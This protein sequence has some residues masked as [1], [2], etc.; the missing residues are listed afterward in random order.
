[1]SP[2]WLSM[3]ICVGAF[4]SLVA[5]LRQTRMSLGLPVAYLFGLL[6]NHLPG[7]LAQSLSNGLLPGFLYTNVGM[8]ITAVSSVS[9]LVGVYLASRGRAPSL[10]LAPADRAGFA[11]F[12]LIGG[13]FFTYALSFLSSIP[14]IGAAVHEGGAIW[15]LGVLLGLR[16][17]IK[18]GAVTAAWLWL[19]ALAVFP[20][21]MLVLGGFLSYGSAAAIVVLSALAISV[22]QT[23]R[24]TV[25]VA[26]VLVIGIGAFVTYYEGR[27]E[28]R[29]AVWGGA[30]LSSRGSVLADVAGNYHLFDPG[31]F[32]DLE[33]LNQRLNQNYFVGLAA[34]RI[35]LHQV[36]YLY[37]RSIEEG[38]I[39]LVPRAMWP[40]K[41]VTAG[42][43]KVIAEM[44]GL[45]LSESTSFGV[46]NV[47]EFYINFGYI[48]TIGGFIILGFLIGYLDRKAA[49]TEARGDLGATILYFLPCVAII[50]PIGSMVELTAGAAAAFIAAYG[51]QFAWRRWQDVGG[52]LRP[53][54]VIAPP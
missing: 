5:M 10:A 30:S 7:A 16:D 11:R 45:H 15:M 54:T 36:D 26:I 47:M 22:R 31:R 4:V 50:Q 1:M 29:H 34:E 37:G 53:T 35:R 44:T 13:W 28:I 27:D 52:Q 48:G 3:L 2:L 21:V 20:I 32:A 43:P 46:G 38:L 6:L 24:L 49:G 18:R 33:A 19:G 9:F 39:A 14:S 42:S 25:G 51:W 40:A 12:C 17:A 23:W 8:Q 41:P